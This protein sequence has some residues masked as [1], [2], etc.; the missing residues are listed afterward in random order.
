MAQLPAVNRGAFR[1]HEAW[2]AKQVNAGKTVKVEIE[3]IYPDAK[4][5]RP[6]R[7]LYRTTIDGVKETVRF[8]N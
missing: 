2:V 1:N 8:E 7:I 4:T 6:S 5:R 3:L